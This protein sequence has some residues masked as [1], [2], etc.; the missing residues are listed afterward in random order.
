[1]DAALTPMR[2]PGAWKDASA[3]TLLKGSSINYLLVEKPAGLE[4]IISQAKANGIQVGD[5]A[6]SGVV[7]VPGVWPGIQVSTPASGASAASGPTG[8]PWVDS[9]GWAARLAAQLHPDSAIWIDAAPKGSRLFAQSYQTAIADTAARG[10]RWV[11]SLDNDLVAALAAQKP[12]ALET[13][14]KISR[15]A[16]FFGGHK[17]WAEY[18]P[19]AVIGLVS[20]FSGDNE[21]FSREVL[22]LLDRTNEQYRII[23]KTKANAAAFKGLRALVYPDAVAPASDLAKQVL[24]FVEAGGLLITG[25][26]WG[27]APGSP[28]KVDENPRY[29]SRIL[30]KGRVAVAK[31]EMD[32]PYLVANDSVVLVSHRFDLVRFWNGGAVGCYLTMPADRKRAALQMLFYAERGGNLQRGAQGD[33]I[34]V[35]IAGRY[36]SG[37][38]WTLDQPAAR[39]VELVP[40]NDGTELRLPDVSGYTAVELS[41]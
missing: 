31:D 9:N 20:D 16:A 6:P 37:K 34:T 27:A 35:R 36:R 3:L 28:A 12:A 13:W 5:A 32:D 38:L 2:W 7:M 17:A 39:D 21:F 1:M 25:P 22:N 8:V 41:V 40:E 30:G 29:S 18:A 24:A 15:A 33:A 19:K 26:K 4:T 11:I 10:G 23:V 14:Q